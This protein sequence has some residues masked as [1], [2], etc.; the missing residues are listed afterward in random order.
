MADS[1]IVFLWRSE[2]PAALP[3][4][5]NQADRG[6][7][8]QDILGEIVWHKRSKR[9]LKD[10]AS[11]GASSFTMRQRGLCT[12]GMHAGPVAVTTP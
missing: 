7:E 4:A 2:E 8:V 9:E 1:P 10:L 12:G 5:L 3:G 6:F 11:G